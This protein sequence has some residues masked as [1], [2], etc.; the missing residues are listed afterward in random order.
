M[1]PG[2]PPQLQA[3]PRDQSGNKS[4]ERERSRRTPGQPTLD[5]GSMTDTVPNPGPSPAAG[6]SILQRTSARGTE[7]TGTP[8]P[9]KR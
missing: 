9:D 4:S 2:V 6:Q 7:E 3:L 8:Q 1:H 5:G